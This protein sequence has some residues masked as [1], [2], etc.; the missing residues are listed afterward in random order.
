MHQSIGMRLIKCNLL[1]CSR[2]KTP[3]TV[4]HFLMVFKSRKTWERKHQNIKKSGDGNFHKVCLQEIRRRGKAPLGLFVS[5]K[6]KPWNNSSIFL[7]QQQQFFSTGN[8]Q[9][10]V[11]EYSISFLTL[12]HKNPKRHFFRLDPL[13]VLWYRLQA[14]CGVKRQRSNLS[15]Q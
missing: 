8:S 10:H 15:T 2:I 12:Q 7:Q 14:A 11:E 13:P 6:G 3:L 9:T 4:L 5:F 1:Y